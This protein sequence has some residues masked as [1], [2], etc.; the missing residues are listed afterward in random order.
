MQSTPGVYIVSVWNS[1]KIDSMIHTVAVE[2][3]Q[4]S[5]IIMKNG[6]LVMNSTTEDIFIT[7]YK[8]SKK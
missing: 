5:D 7:G 2:V 1:N 8:I 4:G 3:L 6:D